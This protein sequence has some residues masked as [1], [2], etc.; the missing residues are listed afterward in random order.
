MLGVAAAPAAAQGSFK[1]YEV[2]PNDTVESVARRHGVRPD[3]IREANKQAITGNRGL[4]A[5]QLIFIPMDEK[6]RVK[7]GTSVSSASSAPPSAPKNKRSGARKATASAPA[8]VT[9][10]TARVGG[11]LPGS[12][13]WSSRYGSG[14][15]ALASAGTRASASTS[16]SR[17]R[18]GASRAA[19]SSTPAP[20]SKIYGSDGSVAIVPS[21]IP[22]LSEDDL[23]EIA[24]SSYGRGGDDCGQNIVARAMCYTGVPYVWGGSTPAGFDCSGYVQY[25]YH[26]FGIDIPRTADVQYEVGLVVPRGCEAPG[27]LVFFETYLPG[28]SHVGIYVGDRQ[29]V[30]ASSSGCVRTSSLD[31]DYFRTRYLGARRPR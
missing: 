19:T 31:E 18:S 25:V 29:F 5:G 24:K 12:R 15:N 17:W 13:E 7:R 28:A 27:D 22:P 11:R 30:H 3:A 4:P 16:A 6:W 9:S 8:A 21:Y 2:Q 10:G 20:K 14:N 26:E 1:Y 23:E